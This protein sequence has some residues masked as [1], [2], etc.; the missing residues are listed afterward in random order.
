[1]E[2]AGVEPQVLVLDHLE[3]R[4]L[5]RPDRT[6]GALEPLGDGRI[7]EVDGPTRV[8]RAGKEHP[9]LLER[10]ADGGDP[11]PHPARVQAELGA[12]G[13]VVAAVAAVQQLGR[14]VVGVD[15][16]AREH[17][18]AAHELDGEIAP[19]HED[20]Q[21]RGITNEHHGGGLSRGHHRNASESGPAEGSQASRTTTP[22]YVARRE[23]LAE[24]STG[25][26]L[27]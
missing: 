20:L 1:M 11:E 6:P 18:G 8:S 23:F 22:V 13:G 17:V 19:Q 27:A 3:E 25:T 14:P 9:R 2:R 26:E 7:V 21:L 4:P 12:G 15:R 5:P 10:L 16:T 24:P